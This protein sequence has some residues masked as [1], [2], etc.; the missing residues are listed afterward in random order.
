M[1]FCLREVV[2]S[3]NIITFYYNSSLVKRFEVVIKVFKLFPVL[4]L[5]E[6]FFYKR[7]YFLT[8]FILMA[9]GNNLVLIV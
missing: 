7:L 6:V 8:G 5:E 2:P 4:W 9:E 3:H 1:T